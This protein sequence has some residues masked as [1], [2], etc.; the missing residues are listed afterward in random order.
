[1]QPHKVRG[2]W[3]P[4]SICL[5]IS[6]RFFHLYWLCFNIP[7]YCKS[8]RQPCHR[9]KWNRLS[10]AICTIKMR[11]YQP[12]LIACFFLM[13]SMICASLFRWSLKLKVAG[14]PAHG[15]HRDPGDLCC[16]WVKVPYFNCVIVALQMKRM[17]HV[18]EIITEHGMLAL[19]DMIMPLKMTSSLCI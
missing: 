12:N 17:F 7:L 6:P 16:L 3:L 5:T 13:L 4:S 1:M 14:S 10:S 18:Y 9:R 15:R 2:V 8:N 11:C 19:P